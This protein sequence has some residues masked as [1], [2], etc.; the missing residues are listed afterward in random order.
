VSVV[1]SVSLASHATLLTGA[2]PKS[3]GISV[4]AWLDQRSRRVYNYQTSNF[5]RI[6]SDL[7]SAVPTAFEYYQ[8]SV[9]HQTL[10]SR[11]ASHIHRVPSQA[12]AR[13][14]ANLLAGIRREPY[15]LH[16]CWLPRGDSAAHLYGPESNN[17]TEE[18]K[19]TFVGVGDLLQ[20]IDRL[21][22]KDDAT[23]LLVSDHGHRKSSMATSLHKLRAV[24]GQATSRWH[25]R[26]N[27]IINIRA[28]P[29]DDFL[30]LTNGG[31]SLYIYTP[32]AVTRST[33]RD[34]VDTLGGSELFDFVIGR[35][36]ERLH[37]ISSVDGTSQITI[38][39]SSDSINYEVLSGS[40]PLD[41]VHGAVE[42]NVQVP[43]LA[44][45]PDFVS[46]YLDSVVPGR[47]PT[48]L[49]F[50]KPGHYFALGP[51]PAWRLGFHQGSHGG[52]L[53]EEVLVS[54]IVQTPT[55]NLK[56]L[57]SPIRSR[58]LLGYCGIIPAH[59]Y[60]AYIK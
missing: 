48:I 19:R 37:R 12:T 35:I 36:S 41:L 23:I 39:G 40:D 32:L 24:S 20:E 52:P 60:P 43:T 6:N 10:V 22:L 9:A 25:L 27:P 15:G 8:H 44:R 21:K 2:A 47:S 17:V 33:L 49:G 18:M 54:A 51:R 34:L 46:Q 56:T 3:H 28:L 1:P 13:L 29:A 30:A 53:P 4:H 11:G 7:S 58:D 5:W 57:L 55:D 16:V 38:T 50:S 31:S 42:L 26:V 45:Y 59:P 14:L